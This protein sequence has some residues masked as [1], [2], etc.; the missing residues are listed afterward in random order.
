MVFCCMVVVVCGLIAVCR[1]LFRVC[2]LGFTVICGLVA[3]VCGGVG[4]G[5]EGLWW[6]ADWRS[7]SV[8]ANGITI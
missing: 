4:F 2:W 8:V 7:D 3:R 1:N 5:S 6:F